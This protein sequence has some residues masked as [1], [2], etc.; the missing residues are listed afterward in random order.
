MRFFKVQD[1][2]LERLNFL[3][4]LSYHPYYQVEEYIV[5]IQTVTVFQLIVVKKCVNRNRKLL[6]NYQGSKDNS[7]S[8][9]Y[10][11]LS[12]TE[13]ATITVRYLLSL[14][15]FWTELLILKVY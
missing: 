1:S 5:V 2:A 6:M 3:L 7:H 10:L 12:L 14:F 15:F 9:A 13:F 8:P 11:I 4:F